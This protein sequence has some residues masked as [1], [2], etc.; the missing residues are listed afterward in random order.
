MEGGGRATEEANALAPQN[1]I[2]E[3]TATPSYIPIAW[4]SVLNT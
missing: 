4:L 1:H 2:K 3:K